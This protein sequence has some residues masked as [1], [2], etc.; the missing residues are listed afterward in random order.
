[1]EY[2]V[3]YKNWERVHSDVLFCGLAHNVP[4]AM[5]SLPHINH[6]I[7]YSST[8]TAQLMYPS[9]VKPFLTPQFSTER[10]KPM[11]LCAT[12]TTTL[13]NYYVPI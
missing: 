13:I 8:F 9:S 11:L 10:V 4:F 1:M 12:F 5:D 7:N 6:L 2:Q 3:Y